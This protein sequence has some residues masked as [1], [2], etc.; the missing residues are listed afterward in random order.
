V[1]VFLLSVALSY[2]NYIDCDMKVNS[3]H[4][5]SCSPGTSIMDCSKIMSTPPINSQSVLPDLPN[6]AFRGQTITIKTPEIVGLGLIGASAGAFKNADSDCP[7]KNAIRASATKPGPAQVEWTAT[8]PVGTSVTFTYAHASDYGAIQRGQKT[9]KIIDKPSDAVVSHFYPAPSYKGALQ[10]TGRI[11]F[12]FLSSGETN[13]ELQLSGVD[14]S[15]P[16]NSRLRRLLSDDKACGLYVKSDASCSTMGN[17]FIPNNT[18]DPWPIMVGSGNVNATI[19]AAVGLTY[20]N[21]QHRA[22]VLYDH[23]G[24]AYACT[25]IGGSHAPTSSPAPTPAKDSAYPFGWFIFPILAETVALLVMLYCVCRKENSDAV[26]I[27]QHVALP[28]GEN[29]EYGPPRTHVQRGSR[30]EGHTS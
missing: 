14:T 16:S 18:T 28:E 11:T 19:N 30:G 22:L 5:A 27:P 6:T 29:K 13:V 8:A 17:D 24:E 23:D 12:S 3:K 21:L 26:A 25:L 4:G 1:Y 2:P 15:C 9:L 20:E 7:N 10:V